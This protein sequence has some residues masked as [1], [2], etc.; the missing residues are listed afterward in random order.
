MSTLT[1]HRGPATELQVGDF[2]DRTF[3]AEARGPRGGRYQARP[4]RVESAVASRDWSTAQA[5][6]PVLVV[7]TVSGARLTLLPTQ[8]VE[9]RR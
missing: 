1:S 2:I 5:R 7:R 4:Y 9:Y 3:G 8:E 6:I